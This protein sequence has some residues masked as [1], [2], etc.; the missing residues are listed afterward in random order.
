MFFWHWPL[1][2]TPW[3]DLFFLH[4]FLG[5]SKAGPW[6]LWWLRWWRILLQC[7]RPG[8]DPW[9]G[10]IPWRRVRQPTPV[11]LPGAS[12]W[13]KEPGRL[14]SMGLQR[15][16]H[17]WATKRTAQ[18]RAWTGVRQGGQGKCFPKCYAPRL[19]LTLLPALPQSAHKC[20]WTKRH[21]SKG[22]QR[23]PGRDFLGE[24]LESA[25]SWH[26]LG[27]SE[28]DSDWGV[29]HSQAQKYDLKCFFL[30]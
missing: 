16:G 10:K 7:R 24:K 27:N 23:H 20:A 4:T 19:A 14:Q 2:P 5:V 9:V 11:F 30:L 21:T 17:S 8:F 22:V 18:C 6:L 28:A 29:G 25:F 13:I 26:F 15:V 1:A 12:P 3:K